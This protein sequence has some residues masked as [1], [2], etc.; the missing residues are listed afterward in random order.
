MLELGI[1][2]K[3]LGHLGTDIFF[4]LGKEEDASKLKD[5][6]LTVEIFNRKFK[7]NLVVTLGGN[8]RNVD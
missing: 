4:L 3:P 5:I 6:S 7:F 8:I 1:Q 2:F